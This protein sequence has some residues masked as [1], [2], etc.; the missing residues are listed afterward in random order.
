MNENRIGINTFGNVEILVTA[1]QCKTEKKSENKRD[2]LPQNE[3]ILSNR[4]MKFNWI[5]CHYR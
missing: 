5:G 3:L 2:A 1:S 4:L